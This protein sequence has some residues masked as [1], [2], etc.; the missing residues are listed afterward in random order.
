MRILCDAGHATESHFAAALTE[1]VLTASSSAL[2][3]PP[4][5]TAHLQDAV[6]GVV[7]ILRAD[8]APLPAHRLQRGFV[9][10]VGQLRPRETGQVT[11]HLL[12]IHV[13]LERLPARVD[14]HVA[15]VRGHSSGM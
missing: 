6:D 1:S 10:H 12:Q 3:S 4:P 9:E 5:L 8:G 2:A 11:C 14:L 13:V 15:Q 7:D